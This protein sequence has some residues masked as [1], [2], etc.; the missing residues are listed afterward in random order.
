MAQRFALD[1]PGRVVALAFLGSPVTRKDKPAVQ[2]L[3]DATISKLR[4]PIHPGLVREFQASTLAR[5]IPASFFEAMVQLTTPGHV[6][7]GGSQRFLLSLHRL[8][9]S[10]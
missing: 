2:E 6:L 8:V 1:H 7:A 3:W 5:P 9:T 10:C 4:D